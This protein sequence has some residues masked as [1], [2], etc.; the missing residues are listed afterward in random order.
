M[1]FPQFLDI[2]ENMLTVSLGG[3]RW[4]QAHRH[5][6]NNWQASVCGFVLDTVVR[7]SVL[8]INSG[9]LR[10]MFEVCFGTFSMDKVSCYLL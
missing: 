8:T 2:S 4:Q 9:I 6:Q 10:F 3:R 1:I 7:L 5:S